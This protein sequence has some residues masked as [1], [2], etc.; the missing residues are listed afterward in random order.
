MAAKKIKDAVV[1][2]GEYQ[3][4]QGETKKQFRTVGSLLQFDDGGTQLILDK[5]FNP[6]GVPGDSCR[7]SFYDPKPFAGNAQSA[8]EPSY[9][10]GSDVPF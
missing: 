9:D 10:A 6:A 3:N 5:S 1:V 7:I 2:V 4:R 8:P